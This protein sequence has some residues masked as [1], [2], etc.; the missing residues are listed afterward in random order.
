MSRL[1]IVTALTSFDK[2]TPSDLKR[3]LSSDLTLLCRSYSHS[4]AYPTEHLESVSKTLGEMQTT[5][6]S[7]EALRLQY[8]QNFAAGRH[9]EAALKIEAALKLNPDNV[10]VALKFQQILVTLFTS[11]HELAVKDPTSPSLS[12]LFSFLHERGYLGIEGYLFAANHFLRTSQ[13]NR[14]KEMLPLLRQLIP[15]LASLQELETIND[16]MDGLADIDSDTTVTVT[17]SAQ[18]H[19]MAAA[20]EHATNL[21]T[22]LSHDQYPL[23]LTETEK[24][25][26]RGEVNTF[27]VHALYMRAI[28]LSCTGRYLEALSLIVKLREYAPY[29]IEYIN[30][31][32]II[33]RQLN[34]RLQ[35]LL[36]RVTASTDDIVRALEKAIENETPGGD[37]IS[38]DIEITAEKILAYG[39]MSQGNYFSY[40][41]R[42]AHIGQVEKALR[43]LQP[44][45]ELMPN[46][47]DVLITIF[48]LPANAAFTPI[49]K[50]ARESLKTCRRLR[51]FD[52]RYW[53]QTLA[54]ISED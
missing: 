37:E 24:V 4:R 27:T 39:T 11:F 30:S 50:L 42:L 1:S 52:F 47:P 14:A 12:L 46:D 51:P 33:C 17:F 53:S 29:R 13:I 20:V 5:Q 41:L 40:A 16:S 45:L 34:D 28:S 36:S 54:E 15:N 10:D 2:P 31:Q 3:R 8:I 49:R 9:F 18:P 19:E 21:E 6:A 23:I 44:Q 22:L 43:F 26:E 7:V 48:R 35:D 32:H 25:A 38:R